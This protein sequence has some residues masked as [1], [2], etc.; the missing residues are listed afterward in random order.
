MRAVRE[1][2]GPKVD[3]LIEVHRRLAPMHAVRVAR[4]LEPF[5]PFWY[6]EPVSARDLG[7][8]AECR[9]EIRMPI[10]TGE[11]LYTRFEFRE[12]FER[13]AADIINPDV[14]NVGGIL[15]L[16]EIA[17]MAEAYH[18]VV[19]PHNYNSTTVGL[20][21][22]LHVS[23]AIPNF[24]ITEYFVNFER[25]RRG[26]RREPVPRRA[27]AMSTVPDRARARHR[28]ARGRAGALR[29]PRVPRAHDP[30]AARR[31]AVARRPARRHACH[32]S[33]GAQLPLVRRQSRIC[34]VCSR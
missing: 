15:E 25:A 7:A 34:A 10:V 14:C 5:D 2:V 20:A 12:V 4:M 33:R 29:L 16:R 6:E 9:R 21:A 28:A 27:A 31:G 18:V 13:R 1:A 3:L 17:A 11:E 22:T 19:S 8:L 26:G 30:D 23:A 32:R 24:L